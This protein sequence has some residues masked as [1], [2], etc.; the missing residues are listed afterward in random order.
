MNEIIDFLQKTKVQYLAT[1]G[2]DDKPKVR[3]F[4]FMFAQNNKLWFCTSNKKETFK[5]IKKNPF[6]EFCATSENVS[7]LRLSGRVLF[8]NDVTVKEKVFEIS[9]LVKS[10]YKD[11]ENPD[12]EVF[13]LENVVATISEFGK[14]PLEFRF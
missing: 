13:Y 9:P 7:W 10:I 3:P 1:V 12:F 11:P 4:Q 8:E 5:E 6:V 14:K 2:L